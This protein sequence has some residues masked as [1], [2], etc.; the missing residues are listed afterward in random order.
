[1]GFRIDA[2]DAVALLRQLIAQLDVVE[3]TAGEVLDALE[4]ARAL[5]IRG[6]GRVHDYLHALAAK[7]VACEA[8]RTWNTGDFEGQFP[9]I[10]LLEP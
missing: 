10:R 9:E 4:S 2:D 5:G 8:I 1:M 3:L 7:Q 6:G